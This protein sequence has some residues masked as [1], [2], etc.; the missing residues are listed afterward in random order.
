MRVGAVRAC[1]PGRNRMALV[2]GVSERL[3]RYSLLWCGL[4]GVVVAKV[5]AWRL[6]VICLLVV[7]WLVW[8]CGVAMAWRGVAARRGGGVPWCGGA[9]RHYG[10]SAR[11]NRDHSHFDVLVGD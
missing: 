11:V 6:C 4:D 7:G 1:T 9:W 3:T 5:V 2:S 8:W 10:V